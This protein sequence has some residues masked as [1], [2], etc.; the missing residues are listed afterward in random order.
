MTGAAASSK[1]GG[2]RKELGEREKE[3]EKEENS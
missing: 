2:K 1:Q 3:K